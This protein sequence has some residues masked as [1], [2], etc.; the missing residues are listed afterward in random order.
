MARVWL[1]GFGDEI[2]AD[3]SVQLAH[4]ASLGIRAIEPRGI[5]GVNVSALTDEQAR[6][7]RQTLDDYGF[8]VSALGSPIGKSDIN[9]PF[10]QALDALLRTVDIARILKAPAI[11][12]FSFFVPQA[13]RAARADECVD[14]LLRMREATAGSGVTLLHENEGGI[15]GETL[16]GCLRIAR[17][18]CSAD[19]GLIFD[20]SNFVQHQGDSLAAWQALKPYVRY[21]HIKDSVRLP[22]G[23]D[24]HVQNPHRVAG[25]GDACI[26]EIL[27]DLKAEGFEGYLSIEP[28]LMS[29]TFVP[30][31]KPEK[32]TAAARALQNILDELNI[33]WREE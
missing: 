17:E 25:T 29:S 3:L 27:A 11:R 19:F 1:T 9:A 30:G 16:E 33:E 24:P 15:Y 10:S 21:L 7:A 2:D 31:D 14:R 8:R 20:P 4:M 6:A 28:H 32:W 5:N 12:M 18:V 13:E 26:R 22:E 23:S